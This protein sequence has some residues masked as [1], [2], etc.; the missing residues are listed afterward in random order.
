MKRKYR[1]IQM[2][3]CLGLPLGT[4]AIIV[5]LHPPGSPAQVVRLILQ[6]PIVW[7]LRDA[8][9]PFS[10]WQC[11]PWATLLFLLALFRNRTARIA[12]C[13]LAGV[14]TFSSIACISFAYWVFP[15]ISGP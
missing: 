6:L 1:V 8:P 7:F 14:L 4:N 10:F 15:D 12:A 2:A 13:S 3:A 11:M 9:A 5:A